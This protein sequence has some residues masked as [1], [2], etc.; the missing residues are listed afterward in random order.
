[1]RSR[2]DALK[3]LMSLYGD[4][5]EMHS[6]ELQRTTA[7]VREAEQAIDVQQ[8]IMRSSGL[9]AR[10]ALISGNLVDW[11]MARTQREIAEWKQQRLQQVRIEREMLN[12]EATKQYLASHLQSEQMKHLVDGIAAQAEI[13]TGRRTQAALDDRFLARRRWTDT[14]DGVRENAK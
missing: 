12:D 10:K 1:V 5:E 11:T 2:L 14:R 3:R 13:M 6:M 7:S 4:V 9:D 8:G